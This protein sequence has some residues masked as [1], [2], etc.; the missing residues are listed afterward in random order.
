MRPSVAVAPAKVA[1]CLT[2]IVYEN[3]VWTRQCDDQNSTNDCGHQTQSAYDGFGRLVGSRVIVDSTYY[4]G[5]GTGYD[6]LGRVSMVTNPFRGTYVN[7]TFGSGQPNYTT[8]DPLGRAKAVTPPDGS[9]E[10]SDPS[11]NVVTC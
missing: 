6:A 5:R 9:V 2:N 3:P 7:T 10:H 1:P 4:V 8:Y 11:E